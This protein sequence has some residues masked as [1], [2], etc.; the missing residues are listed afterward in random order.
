VLIWYSVKFFYKS[1]SFHISH[2]ALSTQHSA[3]LNDTGR[4]WLE[5]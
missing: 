3:L 1:S 4:K 2:S 5:N